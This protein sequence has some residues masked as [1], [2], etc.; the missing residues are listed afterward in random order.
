MKLLV[1]G[2]SGFIGS[3]FVRYWLAAHPKDHII[4]IDLLTYAGN[5]QNLKDI[6]HL[7][8]YRFVHGD[9]CDNN[10]VRQLVSEVD[11]I[12]HFAA[13]SHVDRSIKDPDVFVKTN[14]LGT[15]VLLD[16]AKAHQ[17]RFH[18]VSTD[19]VFGSL[20]LGE[21]TAFTEST[22]YDPR[23]PYSASKA[24]SDHL[25]RAYY[26]TYG[27]PVTIS[28]TSNNFGPYQFP[29]KF[30]PLTITNLLEGKPV[31]LYGDGSQVRDWL[32]VDDHARAIELILEKGKIG[33]TYLVGGMTEDIS[34]KQVALMLASMLEVSAELIQSVKD[35]PGHDVRYSV[36]WSKAKRELGYQPKY[37][38]ESYL[39]DTVNW[40]RHHQAWWKQIKSGEYANYYRTQYGTAHD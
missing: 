12:V 21:S 6:E 25:V 11:C 15:Q 14:V 16:A 35:R 37:S 10:L 7:P 29:E 17:T 2:G 5:P 22:P 36:D 9:I 40:Y 18:H 38:F 31:P 23:S 28:N 1:T 3:N 26:H 8:N 33:E 20:K 13:E 19:E 39:K 24:A 27:L 4:N 30:I 34:N 32:Y